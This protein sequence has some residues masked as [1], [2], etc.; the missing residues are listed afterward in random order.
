VEERT[1]ELSA[2]MHRRMESETRLHQMQKMEAIG[3]LSGGIAH[4][5]NNMMA[6]VLG[7]VRLLE[8]NLARGERDVSKFTAAIREG[9][10]R[11]AVL[12]RRL[13]A[14]ARR[15]PLSP[16]P[17]DVEALVRE[18]TE[19]LRRTIPESIHIETMF[20]KGLWP[21]YVDSGQLENAIFNLAANARDAMPTGGRLTIEATN[22]Y[23]DKADADAGDIAPG[24]YVLILVTDTGRGMTAEEAERAFEP[25]FTT[26]PV[27]RGTGLGL[28]QVYG[29]M[30]QSGGHIKLNNQP[31][32]GLSV[33]LYLPRHLGKATIPGPSPE[34]EMPV[35]NAS[36]G[37]TILVVEDEQAVLEL[38]VGMLQELGYATVSAVSAEE[39][40]E[41]L[42]RHPDIA[43]LLTDVIMPGMNG[44][45]LADAVR[46]KRPGLPV[47][48]VTGYPRNAIVRDGVVD[49][50]VDL[51]T[52]PF[53]LEILAQRVHRALTR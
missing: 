35:R 3:Q 7:G 14:F 25:F 4:D 30:K 27:G 47:L 15:Q 38:T 11:A 44:R 34:A 20:A 13:L 28:A 36:S 49:P 52:K 22:T 12:T 40:L 37:G 8:R 33:K 9:A 5:F 19:L 21:V 42:D 39:A 46:V 23:L 16:S 18:V 45:Q 31:G 29:F 43:L 51:I 50:G 2:E 32:R 6:I 53:T 26:K 1:A 10:E 41:Q 17:T 24:E 48:F